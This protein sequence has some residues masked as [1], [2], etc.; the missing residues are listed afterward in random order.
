[1]SIFEIVQNSVSLDVVVLEVFLFLSNTTKGGMKNGDRRT[2]G[3]SL[4]GEQGF[5]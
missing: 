5:G 3:Y 2:P 1:M 4:H